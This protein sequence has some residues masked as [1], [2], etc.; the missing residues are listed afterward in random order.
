MPGIQELLLTCRILRIETHGVKTTWILG[1]HL[2]N[3][4]RGFQNQ[5][6]D[7]IVVGLGRRVFREEAFD[8]L[9]VLLG[10]ITLHMR[11]AG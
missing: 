3:V 1:Q 8:G 7:W 10:I 9:S 11:H 6:G 4:G 2:L 5:I